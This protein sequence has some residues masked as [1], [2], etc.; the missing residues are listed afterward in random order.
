LLFILIIG[1]P[2]FLVLSAVHLFLSPNWIAFEYG[3]PDFPKA[4]LF[5]D[6]ARLYNATESLLYCTGNRTLAQFVG[7]DVY[8]DRE[9]KHMT[10][11]RL[12]IEKERVFYAVDVVLLLVSLVG[13]G[14]MKETRQSAAQ[15]LFSG[16]VLT[17]VLFLGIAFLQQLAS[18]AF[19]HSFIA[20]FS[21][22]ILGSFCIPTV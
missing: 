6:Q 8:D 14:W 11:V 1:I 16:S 21:R 7:L 20:S 9:I 22:E 15:G 10:D 13:L 3:R 5:S 19:S 17:L 2:P 18:T 12:V 4:E